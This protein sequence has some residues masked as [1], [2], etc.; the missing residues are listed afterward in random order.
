MSENQPPKDFGRHGEFLEESVKHVLKHDPEALAYLGV[1]KDGK[2]IGAYTRASVN[3][4]LL[5]AG[6]IMIAVIMDTIRNNAQ[7]IRD[8]LESVEETPQ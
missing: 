4:K 5:M 2:F 1:L 6:N 3:D 8:I 7:E